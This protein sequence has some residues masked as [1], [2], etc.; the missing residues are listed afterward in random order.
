MPQQRQ[1]HHAR[2]W[3]CFCDH[4]KARLVLSHA[5]SNRECVL[6][7]QKRCE[8]V[9]AR[10]RAAIR[11]VPFRST[12]LEHRSRFL[13]I[14]ADLILLGVVTEKLCSSCSRPTVPYHVMDLDRLDMPVGE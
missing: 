8:A 14:A 13:E 12:I 1:E 10:N 11:Q 7:V 6:D 3:S 5:Q 4:L 9:F 2:R